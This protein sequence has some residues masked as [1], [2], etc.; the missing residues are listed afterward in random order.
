[1]SHTPDKVISSIEIDGSA[2]DVWNALVDFNNYGNWN[3]FITNIDGKANEGEEIKVTIA[4]PFKQSMDFKL[5]VKTVTDG[6][7]MIWLG[8]TLAPNILDGEHFLRVESLAD[9]RT[10]FS[11]GEKFSGKLLYLA[12]P[13]I[14]G[15]VLANFNKMNEALKNKIETK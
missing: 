15:S 5:K 8:Q 7:E 14:K 11:Q 1:M 9:N 6:S 4:L 12:L 10:R 3:P 13:L 2:N